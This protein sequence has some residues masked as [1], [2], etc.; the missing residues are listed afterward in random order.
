MKVFLSVLPRHIFGN[1]VIT[2]PKVFAT[3][4]AAQADC[5][6]LNE[7]RRNKFIVIEMEVDL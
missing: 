7:T 2:S 3:R 5:D 6:K 1:E 4:K